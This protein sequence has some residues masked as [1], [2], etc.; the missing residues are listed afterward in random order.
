MEKGL[1]CRS[2]I[3]QFSV[4]N[5]DGMWPISISRILASGEIEKQYVTASESRGQV[6]ISRVT[7]HVV[8]IGFDMSGYGVYQELAHYFP[9]WDQPSSIAKRHPRTIANWV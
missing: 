1:Y 9:H 7:G 5:D 8:L 2:S 3:E 6:L 4:A